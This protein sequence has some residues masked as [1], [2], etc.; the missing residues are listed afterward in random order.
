M[1]FVRDLVGASGSGMNPGRAA[2]AVAELVADLETAAALLPSSQQ[3]CS[4][5][6][7]ASCPRA[8]SEAAQR[9]ARGKA[10]GMFRQGAHPED[11]RAPAMLSLKH[12]RDGCLVLSIRKIPN[13]P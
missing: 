1:I 7:S 12:P 2:R 10:D 3:L 9:E 5:G 4:S 6:T 11:P 8:R 13:A